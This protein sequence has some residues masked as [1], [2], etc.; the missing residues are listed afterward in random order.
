MSE[1]W[2]GAPYEERLGAEDGA[3]DGA[4]GLSQAGSILHLPGAILTIG[5]LML[6]GVQCGVRSRRASASPGRRV[7]PLLGQWVMTASG[8]A[9][10]ETLLREHRFR[11]KGGGMLTAATCCAFAC[12]ATRCAG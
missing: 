11:G 2:I 4:M 8:V 7:L 1:L 3:E 6:F 9:A 12:A 10:R 5:Y